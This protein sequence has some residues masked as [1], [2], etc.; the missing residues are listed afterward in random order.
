MYAVATH[1]SK[2]NVCRWRV[3]TCNFASA[4]LLRRAWDFLGV[5]MVACGAPL[6][7]KCVC[8]DETP[9]GW[10]VPWV[11]VSNILTQASSKISIPRLSLRHHFLTIHHYSQFLYQL[12]CSLSMRVPMTGVIKLPILGGSNFIQTMVIL[13]KIS[14]Y[15]FLCVCNHFPMSPW[16]K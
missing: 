8:K 9:R 15:F 10:K 16:W 5:P 11:F 14:L 1:L 6:S 12:N 2:E 7:I 13:V 4:A 3:F